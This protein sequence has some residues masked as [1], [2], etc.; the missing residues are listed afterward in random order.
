MGSSISAG[1]P[2]NPAS[3]TANYDNIGY[4]FGTSSDIFNGL[5]GGQCFVPPVENADLLGVLEGIIAP[6]EAPAVQDIFGVFPNP[7]FRYAGSPSVRGLPQ[8][9]LSDG[10]LT[11][12]NNPIWPFIQPERNVDVLIVNDNSADTTDNFPNGTEIRQTYANAR[13]FGLTKMPFI[14]QVSVFVSEGLNKRATFFGCDGTDTIFII[15]IPNV[16]YTFN[17]GQPTSKVQYSRRQTDA[18]IANGVEV[19]TQNGDENWPLCLACA[20]A[21][22]GDTT[23]SGLPDGCESCFDQYC[24]RRG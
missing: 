2:V 17:S 8:L 12:Q 9:T 4:V 19:G 22:G 11:G 1:S 21:S 7:F 24:Y 20:I 3:C 18:M 15:Y 5:G 16:A 23:A 6:V 13:A 14:P 10:G